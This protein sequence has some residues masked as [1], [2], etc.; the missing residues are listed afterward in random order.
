MNK[1]VF[2]SELRKKL[3]GLP[4]SDID[5]RVSFYA[6]MIDDRVEDGMTEEAAVEQIGSVDKV[7]ETIMSEYPLS[8]LVKAKVKPEKKMPVWAIV[9][10]ILG[11]P[12]WFPLLVSIVSTVGSL[13]LTLW[14]IVITLYAVDLAFAVGSIACLIAMVAGFVSGEA[15]FGIAAFGCALVLGALAVLLFIGS[16]YTVKGVVWLTKKMLLGIKSLFIGKE[17]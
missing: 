7:V 5:E 10:L 9:L 14:C 3:S 17:K 8:K 16:N 6:E 11:F 15:M 13:Y 1:E 2:L 4:Q 12:V